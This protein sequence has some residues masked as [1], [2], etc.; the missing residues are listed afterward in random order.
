MTLQGYTNMKRLLLDNNRIGI[1][2]AKILSEI[3]PSLRLLELNIGFNDIKAEGLISIVRCLVDNTVLESLTLSG[4]V[5]DSDVSR[6]IAYMLVHNTVLKKLYLD[7]TSMSQ[8]SE[9]NIAAGIASSKS[10][11]LKTLTGFSLGSVLTTLGSP[12][13]LE[14]YTNDQVLRYLEDMWKLQKQAEIEKY[15]E[16]KKRYLELH[17]MKNAE[18]LKNRHEDG[19]E[20]ASVNDLRIDVSS[21]IRI[22][23]GMTVSIHG[24][25]ND[26]VV[27][28]DY[29]DN[30]DVSESSGVVSPIVT[31]DL[32]VPYIVMNV[33]MS[34]TISTNTTKDDHTIETNTGSDGS[35]SSGNITDCSEKSDTVATP[36][37]D[38][39]TEIDVGPATPSSSRH[40]TTNIPPTTNVHPHTH[41]DTSLDTNTEYGTYGASTDS[42]VKKFATRDHTC[43][44]LSSSLSNLNT[45]SNRNDESH[46]QTGN[47]AN[48]PDNVK[49]S[50]E[51]SSSRNSKKFIPAQGHSGAHPAHPLEASS[52]NVSEHFEG[53]CEADMMKRFSYAGTSSSSLLSSLIP[54]FLFFFSSFPSLCPF[55]FSHHLFLSYPSFFPFS[56]FSP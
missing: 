11:S 14:T 2:G 8:S 49:K 32:D 29:T 52:K 20:N 43:A 19:H 33:L 23:D 34:D 42:A 6:L 30:S 26:Y 46:F 25:N 21:D 41:P 38:R 54:L 3:L 39:D 36:D 17:A 51:I 10:S 12:Q 45:L 22:C 55:S 48:N 15:E 53:Y 24:N 18:N 13:K 28:N 1:K 9:K 27:N 16:N 5:L 47:N 50:N 7:R 4:N 40:N 37:V 56:S 44:S 35:D 31:R